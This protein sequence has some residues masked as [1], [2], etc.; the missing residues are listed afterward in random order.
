MSA[1]LQTTI[2]LLLLGFCLA[3]Q[4]G[5]TLPVRQPALSLRE[6]PGVSGVCPSANLLDQLKNQAVNEIVT[7]LGNTVVPELNNRP[8][9]PCG[10]AGDW[11]TLANLD[12]SD[13]N[14]QCPSTW[15]LVA[16][17]ER[18]CGRITYGQRCDSA[19]FSSNGAAYSRVCG[20]ILAY[21]RGSPDAFSEQESGRNIDNVETFYL[22]GVSL[23]H[24]SPGS[25]Q[26]IWSFVASVYETNG[27]SYRI[28]VNCPCTNTDVT[29][30][31]RIPTFIGDN[32]FCDTGNPG[33][34]FVN[35]QYPDDPMWDGEGCGPTN[36]CCQ[37][38]NPPWFCTTLPA[39]TTDDLE[40]RICGDENGEDAEI[41]RVQL[42][43][44]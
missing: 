22:D 34:G 18:A 30:N 10:G 44:M 27:D 7:V 13:P 9:C 19:Y 20:R 24:G 16:S 1:L 33:P 28:D 2:S 3:Q 39:S 29:F 23:T 25:R 8:F 17:P 42:Y 26:H 36:A 4:N 15:R 14:Q 5:V 32:Y 40:V 35:E 6:A 43:V 31:H 12:M 37:L 21:Q 38:N 11:Q 41:N